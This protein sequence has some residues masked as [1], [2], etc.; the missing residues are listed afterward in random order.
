LLS[1]LPVRVTTTVPAG[2]L[3]AVMA[4]EE[5]G[6]GADDTLILLKLFAGT[7]TPDHGVAMALPMLGVALVQLEPEALHGT[8]MHNLLFGTGRE[9]LS[10]EWAGP[11]IQ[12]AEQSARPDHSSVVHRQLWTL[13]QRCGLSAGLI[14]TRHTP[15][16]GDAIVE[17]RRN[18]YRVHVA[19]LARIA[20]VRAVLTQPDVLLLHG[21]G[22]LWSLPQQ[23]ALVQT[24]R[25]FVDGSLDAD[26]GALRAFL[27]GSSHSRRTPRTVLWSHPNTE[28]LSVND[29]MLMLESRRRAML[30]PIEQARSLAGRRVATSP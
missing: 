16:W 19:D 28:L 5:A 27:G 26:L 11:S 30:L 14:G 23:Q 25:S 21:I 17:S 10:E 9:R 13:C 2:H 20:L 8:L 22:S 29:L 6:M 1:P 24:V 7:L 3:I 4:H 12:I 15:A 18:S